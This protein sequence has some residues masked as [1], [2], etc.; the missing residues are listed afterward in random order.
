MDKDV[1]VVECSSQS[2]SQSSQSYIVARTPKKSTKQKASEVEKRLTS[3]IQSSKKKTSKKVDVDLSTPKSKKA[4]D[5]VMLEFLSEEDND[6]EPIQMLPAKKV[7]STK[8]RRTKKPE[9]KLSIIDPSV[10]PIQVVG[11]LRLKS[12]YGESLESLQSYA[13]EKMYPY[14][15]PTAE[16]TLKCSQTIKEKFAPQQKVQ[17][18]DWDIGTIKDQ[19]KTRYPDR[20]Q[21]HDVVS[22]TNS[23]LTI[24]FVIV[25]KIDKCKE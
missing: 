8:R 21:I 4:E 23:N 7:K 14:Q 10:I 17:N 6:S 11:E 3:K 15:N 12:N 22:Q 13:L 24:G 5:K 18:L 19:L 16:Q 1:Q 9:P 2:K 25:P 20:H